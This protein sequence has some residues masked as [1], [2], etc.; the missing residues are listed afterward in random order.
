MA[1]LAA[2]ALAQ[3]AR[4]AARDDNPPRL[5]EDA[6][7]HFNG[8][9]LEVTVIALKEAQ[10]AD[11]GLLPAHVLM[12][13]VFLRIAEPAAAEECLRRARRLGADPNIVW[14]L[15]AEAMYWQ[16]QYE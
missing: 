2:I 10:S 3:P 4:A 6:V 16:R 9:D 12:A 8:G 15:Q 11:P 5:Y 7:R 14:P 13:R 1:V